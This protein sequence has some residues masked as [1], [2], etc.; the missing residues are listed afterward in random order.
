MLANQGLKIAGPQL[1]ATASRHPSLV[2]RQLRNHSLCFAVWLHRPRSVWHP[3]GLHPLKPPVLHCEP[4][5][6]PLVIWSVTG[7]NV[8]VAV[9]A[10]P[11]IMEARL[12][13][14]IESES[15]SHFY[16]E[17]ARGRE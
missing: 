2:L 15:H 7:R 13:D 12:V 9:R 16:R 3:I 11:D 17:E 8:G 6:V 1:P 4:G 14:V 5:S 10:T